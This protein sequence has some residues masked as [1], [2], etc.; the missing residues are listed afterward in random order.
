MRRTGPALAAML[1]GLSPGGPVAAQE[2]AGELAARFCAARTA[3]DEEATRALAS[4]ALL[5]AIAEAERRN[6]AIAAA[7]PGEKPPLGDGI[8]W[9]AFPDMAPQC[10]PG[11]LRD[12]GNR[13]TVDLAYVF[14]GL[15]DGGW[16][17]RVV[18]VE[19]GGT[20]RVDDVLYQQ[21][22]TDSTQHG[23]RRTLSEVFD[24]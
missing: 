20:R 10:T 24:H 16:T 12:G 23:L 11:A 9:Q 5:A 13:V 3:G 2:T 15:K 14:P 18:I 21:F 1:W 7:Q 17:D 6:A 22:T 19:E 8:P 4:Q